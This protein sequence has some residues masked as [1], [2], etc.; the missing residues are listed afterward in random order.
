MRLWPAVVMQVLALTRLDGDL[1][2]PHGVVLKQEAMIGRCGDQRVQMRR[3]FRIVGLR[4]VAL[5]E[6]AHT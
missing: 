4:H 6:E 5:H 2:H 3:L 1:Q